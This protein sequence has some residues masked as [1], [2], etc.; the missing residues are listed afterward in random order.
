MA[1]FAWAATAES[2]MAKRLLT[3]HRANPCHGGKSRNVQKPLEHHDGSGVAEFAVEKWPLKFRDLG[4]RSALAA[5][6][7]GRN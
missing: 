2:K 6:V 5:G 4:P 1:L 3:W 7:S